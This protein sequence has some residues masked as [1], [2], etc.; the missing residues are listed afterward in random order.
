MPWKHF[1]DHDELLW[2]HFSKWDIKLR[3]LLAPVVNYPRY[4]TYCMHGHHGMSFCAH[5]VDDFDLNITAVNIFHILDYVTHPPF[6]E[7]LDSCP[8][9]IEELEFRNACRLAIAFMRECVVV[10]PFKIKLVFLAQI[11]SFFSVWFFIFV[12]ISFLNWVF[13]NATIWKCLK[14]YMDFKFQIINTSPML[15]IWKFNR[16]YDSNQKI[17]LQ[18]NSLICL[19]NCSLNSEKFDRLVWF[20]SIL[21]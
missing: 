7:S 14:K 5:E 21:I 8:R 10:S 15:D 19:I 2:K 16:W 6:E 11:V 1:H 13:E 9:D 12:F 17:N 3:L 4:D 18:L 20:D